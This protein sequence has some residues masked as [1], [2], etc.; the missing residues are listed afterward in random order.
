MHASTAFLI[1]KYDV[2]FTA[3]GAGPHN[4]ATA[5]GESKARP[6]GRQVRA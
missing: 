1:G 3:V 6:A 2:V 5:S 4:T